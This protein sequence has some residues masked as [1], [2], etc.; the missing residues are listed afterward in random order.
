MLLM[1]A[2]FAGCGA[3]RASVAG[4]DG[5]PTAKRSMQLLVLFGAV[6]TLTKRDI[7]ARF[8]APTS[9]RRLA[10]H[11]EGWTYGEETLILRG[12]RVVGIRA[13]KIPIGG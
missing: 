4:C 11:R 5:Y 7:C 13:A 12:N 3:G 8:G 6:S 1:T 9:I 10:K 2:L